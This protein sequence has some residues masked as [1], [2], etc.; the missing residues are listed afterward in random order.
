MQ[1]LLIV[2]ML[3]VA[4]AHTAGCSRSRTAC[5]PV[6]TPAPTCCGEG[7]MYGP[8]GA[9]MTTGPAVMSPQIVPGPETYT[10]PVTP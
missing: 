2:T 4:A 7:E 3:T 5:R 1:R 8:P 9:V 6:C 10:T